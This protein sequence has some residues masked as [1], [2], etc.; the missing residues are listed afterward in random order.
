MPSFAIPKFTVLLEPLWVSAEFCFCQ[1]V[2]I[3]T[4]AKALKTEIETGL[5]VGVDH[6]EDKPMKRKPVKS[7]TT[8]GTCSSNTAR[9]P[10]RSRSRSLT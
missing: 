4:Q 5:Q 9:C 7:I 8:P 1:Q 10:M 6:L 2:P 3:L